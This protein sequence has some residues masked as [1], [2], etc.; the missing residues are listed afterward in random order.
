[1][2]RVGRRA[3]LVRFA[4]QSSALRQSEAAL[5]EKPET[6][7][8]TS[9]RFALTHHFPLITV[10]DSVLVTHLTHPDEQGLKSVRP[11]DDPPPRPP[12]CAAGRGVLKSLSTQ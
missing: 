9:W 5:G 11:S 6:I 10:L 7:N 1:M 4:L 2:S 12:P 3:A 8:T